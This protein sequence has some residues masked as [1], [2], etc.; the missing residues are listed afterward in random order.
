M[1]AVRRAEQVGQ[2]ANPFGIE[3]RAE[4]ASGLAAA[5]GLAAL[6]VHGPLAALRFFEQARVSL[7]GRAS[8]PTAIDEARIAALCPTGGALVWLLASRRRSAAIVA[9]REGATVQFLTLEL[10]LLDDRRLREAIT[11]WLAALTTTGTR[12]SGEAVAALKAALDR[13]LVQLGRRLA[14]PLDRLLRRI[15]IGEGAE[16]VLI[17]GGEAALPPLHA[18][19]ILG[20][21]LF[22]DRY[23]L[24]FVPR[25]GA[26]AGV[27]DAGSATR[28]ATSVILADPDNLGPVGVGEPDRIAALFRQAGLPT[29]RIV[30]RIRSPQEIVA[31]CGGARYLHVTAHSRFRF[32]DP[33]HSAIVIGDRLFSALHVLTRQDLRGCELAFLANCESSLADAGTGADL[34]TGLAAAVLEAGAATVV[35]AFWPTSDVPAARIVDGFYRRMLGAGQAPAQAL[36]EAMHERPGRTSRTRSTGHPSS[37]RGDS[38]TGLRN[39][40]AQLSRNFG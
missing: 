37:C 24:R 7:S 36:R 18:A 1:V 9:L 12:S 3:E 5:G 23:R 27:D 22:V 6:E 31:L 34:L 21:Q 11:Q 26:L 39:P 4:V 40:A 15:G 14:R 38:R 35:G 33:L 28:G 13:L 10:A 8:V 20:G 16:I 2:T 30:E 25:L 19:P 17:A 32:A 29:R